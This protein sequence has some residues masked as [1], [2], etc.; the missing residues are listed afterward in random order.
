[1]IKRLFALF[2]NR[3][4]F[5]KG[6]A[7]LGFTA[8]L[9]NL[10]GLWRDRLLAQSFGAS[11]PL[12]AYNAAFILP[13]LLLN[14]FVAGAVSAA[15]VPIFT[16]LLTKEKR[17]EAIRFSNS[18]LN[19]SLLV[20]L[21]TGLLVFILAP[22]LS[23]LVVPGFDA[24]SKALFVNL[25]RLL[26]LSPII[27]AASNTLGSV[28]V[29][30]E[31]FFWYGI[32][33]AIYNLGIIGGTILLAQR[34]GIY[35]V[36]IGTLA[37]ALLHLVSRLIGLKK[38][39]F[40]YRPEIKLDEHLK[41]Y[42]RL[43]L[44]RMAGHP[45]EQFIFLG[46]TVIASTISTGSIV[47]LTFAN[48][49]QTVPVAILGITLALTAFPVLSRAVSNR[50]KPEFMDQLA[51]TLK[52]ILLT[53]IPAALFMYFFRRPIIN[54]LLGGGEFSREAV[55]LT[56]ATLG[57]FSLSIVTE[58]INHLLARAFY[59]LKNSAVPT[60]IAVGGLAVTLVSAYYFSGSFGVKGLALGFFAGSMFKIVLH[61]GFL[62][63][64]ANR[65][66]DR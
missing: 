2:L 20:I 35:G 45:I 59:A 54:I 64:Q 8:I 43:M 63:K 57:V 17:E 7:I 48:N 40:N 46:F 53:T 49:F 51:F 42:I 1:M 36:I 52:A 24:E 38:R 25:M 16:D 26:L 55:E 10:L 21:A 39:Y 50:N 31:R 61:F 62:K 13:N 23:H 5:F 41:K 18:V 27:F 30:E 22:Q 37:G 6:S 44:P 58:S 47:V 9:S 33:P 3:K 19:G 34:F 29:S 56:A 4:T 60:L 28:L 65:E 12:D 32:S 14:I 11:I 66:F 15:F